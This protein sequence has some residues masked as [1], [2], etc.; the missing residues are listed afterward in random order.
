[1]AG[2]PEQYHQVDKSDSTPVPLTC[3]DL[4]QSI[5]ADTEGT[6]KEESVYVRS[7]GLDIEFTDKISVTDKDSSS[8]LVIS[9]NTTCISETKPSSEKTLRLEALSGVSFL[10]EL[11][12]AQAQ[13]STQRVPYSGANVM[14]LPTFD[15]HQ[16]NMTIQERDSVT[17]NHI[18]DANHCYILG[19][20]EEH[21]NSSVEEQKL[22][23]APEIHL[24]DVDSLI[25]GSDALEY[26]NSDPLSFVSSSRTEGLFS[27]SSMDQ[28]NGKLLN[29]IPRNAEH[30]EP[31]ILDGLPSFQN[32][33]GLINS[34]FDIGG[35]NHTEA[36]QRL[37]EMEMRANAKHVRPAA[38]GH[39]PGTNGPEFGMIFRYR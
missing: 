26:V 21:E 2:I 1:M 17:S 31:S 5:L 12:S 14:V 30:V 19:P 18:H 34:G 10:K 36:F 23:V 24:P 28:L 11:Q 3:E 20:D 6:K 22:G 35:G 9:K 37:M 8:N 13:V 7:P 27:Q 25:I 4:E 32:S 38:A 16:P 29:D 33:H 39:I 15:N